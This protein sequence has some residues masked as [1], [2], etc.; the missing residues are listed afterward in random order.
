MSPNLN[1]L[2]YI[3]SSSNL[4][5]SFLVN[6]PFALCSDFVMYVL[7][8]LILSSALMLEYMKTVSEVVIQT[9]CEEF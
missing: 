5:I 3:T 9:F 8:V 7:N 1:T 4:M 6:I 2:L